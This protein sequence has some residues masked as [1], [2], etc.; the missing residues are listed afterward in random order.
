MVGDAEHVGAVTEALKVSLE[1]C[2]STLIGGICRAHPP[3]VVA[4]ALG[5]GPSVNHRI[6][7]D[8]IHLLEPF[9]AVDDW[10]PVFDGQGEHG[11][12]AVLIVNRQFDHLGVG[13]G[14]QAE[15]QAVTVDRHGAVQ[16]HRPVHEQEHV[17]GGGRKAEPL[18]DEQQVMPLAKADGGFGGGE[19]VDGQGRVGVDDFLFRG[20]TDAARHWSQHHEHHEQQCG[21]HL[22]QHHRLVECPVPKD[23]AMSSGWPMT[24]RQ[25]GDTPSQHASGYGEVVII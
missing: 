25:D 16:I 14:Q 19:P 24:S 13:R 23:F 22:R 1:I 18:A 2:R 11:L 5:G 12:P 17:V 21:T 8:V 4:S 20:A 10:C 6:A 15:G 7:S 3:V 9:L